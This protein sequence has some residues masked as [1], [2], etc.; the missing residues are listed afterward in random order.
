LKDRADVIVVAGR[1]TPFAIRRLTR[2]CPDVDLVVSTDQGAVLQIVE[3]GK[4][5]LATEDRPGFLGQTYVTYTQ[6][7]SYGLTGVDLALD[8]RH[9][10]VAADEKS[11]WLDD[12]VPDDAV[13]RERLGRFYDRVGRTDAAQAGVR[14]PFASDRERRVGRYVG[15]ARCSG[16]HAAEFSQ[17]RTTAHATAFKTLLDVHRHY[18]PRCVACHVVGYGTPSGYRMGDPTLALANVQCEVCHG[19]G[20]D[21]ADA[22]TRGNILRRVPP[23][24]CLQCHDSEHS[25][26]FVYQERL[27]RVLHTRASTT[28]PRDSR[29]KGP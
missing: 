14:V 18:Q 7:T 19:P 26:R 22:P 1:I 24:V 8:D 15:A 25:E 20:G 21:H 28:Q 6:L 16:C 29:P 9:R 11:Y 5:V 12:K 10:V 2:A 17:W 27:P 23:G 3:N 4:N 13:V